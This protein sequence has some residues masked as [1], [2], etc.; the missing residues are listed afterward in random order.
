M[1]FTQ[2]ICT[3]V[4]LPLTQLALLK[5]RNQ[6]VFIRAYLRSV[7][8]QMQ[9]EKTLWNIQFDGSFPQGHTPRD[10]RPPGRTNTPV[11]QTQSFVGGGDICATLPSFQKSIID[12]RT[13]V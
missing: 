11:P 12:K 5:E 8:P 1:V 13:R 6:H 9:V 4:L 2:N 7:C 10:Q 3:P